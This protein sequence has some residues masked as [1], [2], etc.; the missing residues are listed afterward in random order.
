[1]KSTLQVNS[2]KKAFRRKHVLTDIHFKLAQG[3]IIGLLG[4]NGCGKS[5][6]LKILFG[7]LKADAFDI[8]IN[9]K[10]IKASE[11]I[12]NQYIGY[13]PQDSFLPRHIKVRDA[14]PMFF[15]DGDAQDVIFR[16]PFIEEIAAKKT[17]SL[18]L[19]QLR[20]LE[21]LLVAHLPHPFLLL[22]EPF[23]MIEPQY[24]EVI[25]QL[26][27][28]LK[29]KKGILLTDHY[30]TDVLRISDTNWILRNGQLHQAHTP[31]DLQQLEYLK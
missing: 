18:S 5:T 4:R 1:M 6:L 13:L 24:K 9:V 15:N 29:A 28:S 27:L 23:S 21:V 16:I 8:N 17:G 12:P 3:E 30:Y 22:D 2:I 7:T 20:Y 26:L 14:I 11:I 10:P 31:E 25:S 19:G